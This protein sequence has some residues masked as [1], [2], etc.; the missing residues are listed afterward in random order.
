MSTPDSN[1]KQGG[2][3]MKKLLAATMVLAIGLGLGA[4]A[5][6][7]TPFVGVFFD[8]PLTRMDKNCPNGGGVDSAFVVAR[9]FN[10]FIMGLEYSIN[11][12]PTVTWLSD[13]GYP[14]VTIGST[15]TGISEGFPLPQNGFEPIIVCKIIF[16]WNC[17][18]CTLTDDPIVVSPHPLTGFVRAVDFPNYDF[19]NA[20]GMTSLIC[21][22]VPTQDTSWG[23]IKSLYDE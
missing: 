10:A 13:Y 14:P 15:P 23:K 7:Q 9:N 5:L 2:E 19:I 16:L 8:E 20:V 3:L 17:D 21:A 1:R 22:T 11:Y 4:D 18:G 6:A 12:G